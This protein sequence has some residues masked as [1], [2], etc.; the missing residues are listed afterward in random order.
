[1]CVC[2]CVCVCVCL[3]VA[4]VIQ[5]AKRMRRIIMS[6]VACLYSVFP[7]YLIKVKIFGGGGKLLVSFYSP[8]DFCLQHVSFYAEL[9]EISCIYTGRH[10]KSPLLLS[11]F[12]ET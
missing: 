3:C 12:H 4:L 5:H 6:S 1:M 9:G 7:Y 10:V 2:V 8:H 11:D